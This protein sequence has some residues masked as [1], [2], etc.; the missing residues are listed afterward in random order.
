AIVRAIGALDHVYGPTGEYRRPPQLLVHGIDEAYASLRWVRRV[1]EEGWGLEG[2]EGE[3]LD[4]IAR[5]EPVSHDIPRD[6]RNAF[7]PLPRKHLVELRAYHL[8]D[9]G[10]PETRRR[11]RDIEARERATAAEKAEVS[12]RIPLWERINIFSKTPDK[13][14]NRELGRDLEALGTELAAA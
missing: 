9:W 8:R 7:A 3:L 11:V 10:Y 1:L 4:E 5:A 13:E 2:T 6:D 14:R 12:A